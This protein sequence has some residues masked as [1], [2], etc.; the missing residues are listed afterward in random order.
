MRGL[1]AWYPTINKPSFAPPGWIFAPVWTVLFF[2]MGLALW[3]VWRSDASKARA[4][5][6][7]CFGVQLVLNGLWSWIFFAWQKPL[8]AF[9]EIV[10]LDAAILA[11]ILLFNRVRSSASWLMVPY[12]TWCLFATLLTY[13]TWKMNTINPNAKEEH[14]QINLDDESAGGIQQGR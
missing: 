6:V 10:A 11:T 2:L 1:Q 4:W 12:L 3:Q 14:I 13:G 5:G 8:P 9:V 7:A